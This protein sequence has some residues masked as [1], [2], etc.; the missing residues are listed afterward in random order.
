[1]PHSMR[2]SKDQNGDTRER[3]KELV[4]RITA[5]SLQRADPIKPNIRERDQ[6][7]RRRV[8][9]EIELA[10]VRETRATIANVR[11]T[12]TTGYSLLRR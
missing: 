11:M 1:M 3:K 9:E 12:T 10:I 4:L 2:A 8:I 5:A 6:E 7:S